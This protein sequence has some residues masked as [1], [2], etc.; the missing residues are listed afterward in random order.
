MLLTAFLF[1]KHY[2]SLIIAALI[3]LLPS[4]VPYS[5]GGKI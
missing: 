5:L 2:T 1:K 4:A 3:K